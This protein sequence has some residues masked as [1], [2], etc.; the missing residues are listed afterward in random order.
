MRTRPCSW[1]L[2]L[3]FLAT[4]GAQAGIDSEF[5]LGALA[6]TANWEMGVGVAGPDWR[7]VPD[8]G[9]EYLGFEPPTETSSGLVAQYLVGF[10]VGDF[11]TFGGIEVEAR[12]DN[13]VADHVEWWPPPEPAEVPFIGVIRDP[14]WLPVR[15]QASKVADVV[16]LVGLNFGWARAFAGAGVSRANVQARYGR[17]DLELP[18][19]LTMRL[20]FVDHQVE[21]RQWGFR[22][23]VGIE[24]AIG[25][26]LIL[27][28]RSSRTDYGKRKH[29]GTPQ[30]PIA[31]LE[32]SEYV[33]TL[34]YR[35]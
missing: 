2:L 27:Q 33:A 13:G 29:S 6:S 31:D 4:P 32:L 19:P 24:A 26:S 25:R 21:G 30:S 12:L 15:M 22:Q 17:E 18:A 28:V 11:R 20:V 8:S 35:F 1:T 10:G 34:L 23:D 7:G 16:C 9:F 5:R 14:R 3:G